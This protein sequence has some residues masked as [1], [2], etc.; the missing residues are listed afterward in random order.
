MEK[1]C[2]LAA[3]IR[4]EGG[5]G[6]EKPA[7]E[8]LALLVVNNYK[9]TRSGM[10]TSRVTASCHASLVNDASGVRTSNLFWVTSCPVGHPQSLV[11]K[12]KRIEVLT[13]GF[14]EF[15]AFG[16]GQI[17]VSRNG[18]GLRLKRKINVF[19]K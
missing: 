4:I 16:I 9:L 6:K 8:T 3:I 2:T 19:A 5:G 17:V 15:V 14:R 11:G 13:V 18:D 1:V 10:V 7:A 12:G